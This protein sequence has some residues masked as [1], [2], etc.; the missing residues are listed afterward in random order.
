MTDKSYADLVREAKQRIPEVTPR[1][2]LAMQQR[3][4]DA[5][6]L[7]VREMNEWNLGHLPLAMHI[8][9]GILEQR[10]EARIPRDRKV[11]IYCASGNRSALAAD[12]MR[13]MGYRDVASMSRGFRG[14]VEEGGE[15]DG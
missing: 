3:G 11:I 7:D 10:V 14:W 8:P 15:V 1:D 9:R 2:V 12:V 5:V 4:D 6:Y 13:E